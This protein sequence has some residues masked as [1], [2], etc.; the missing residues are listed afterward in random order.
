MTLVAIDVLQFT[1][2]VRPAWRVLRLVDPLSG[3]IAGNSG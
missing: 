3:G 2:V 1:L